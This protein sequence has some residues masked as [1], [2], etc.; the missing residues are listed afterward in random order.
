M[1]HHFPKSKSTVVLLLVVFFPC[2][3]RRRADDSRRA[4]GG[5][6]VSSP[7]H[8]H[9]YSFELAETRR[10][11]RVDVACGV[12]LSCLFEMDGGGGGGRFVVLVF[13]SRAVGRAGD[14]VLDNGGDATAVMELP[15]EV[16]VL[17]LRESLFSAAP[18]VFVSIL[19]PTPL[20]RRFIVPRRLLLLPCAAAGGG[21]GGLT[22][23]ESTNASVLESF[24]VETSVIT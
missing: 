9:E 14:K 21:G 18:S 11:F 4:L 3:K 22:C 19:S 12:S 20:Y 15:L 5:G 10:L 23:G 6:T 16:L 1:S 17:V 2:P 13:A 24:D 7:I 8:S